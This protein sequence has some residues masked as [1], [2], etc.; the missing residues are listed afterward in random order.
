MPT[1]PLPG[2]TYNGF[3]GP[4]P[5]APPPSRISRKLVIGGVAGAIALGLVFGLWAR[6]DFGDDGKVREPVKTAT[7]PVEV[8]APVMAPVPKSIGR[9]EVLSPEQANAAPRPAPGFAP[10]RIEPVVRIVEP[11]CQDGSAADQLVC[12]DL[13]LT[14]ADR[15]MNRA[16]ER[17]LR[18]G[19]PP[20]ELRAEQD[21]WMEI[22]EDAA[23]RSP[24]ALASV[25]EQRI[26]ELN[27]LADG[28]Y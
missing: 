19:V 15:Q 4:T 13:R 8:N 28:D 9:L 5:S 22:R 7:L 21:D 3:S 10:P 25:Y 26:G 27:A 23:E 14:S 1:D 18:S 17:A 12:G 20:R 6:P 24:R 2:G 16:Y 11:T